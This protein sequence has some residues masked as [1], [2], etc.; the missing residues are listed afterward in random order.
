LLLQLNVNNNT[1]SL[2]GQYSHNP[3]LD[4]AFTGSMSV[5]PN[6]NALVGWGSK[7]FFSEYGPGGKLLLDAVWPGV[8]L[9]YRVLLTQNWVGK[10]FYPPSGAVR[11][12]HGHSTV[13]ASWDGA[14]QVAFWQILAGRRGHLKVITTVPKRGFE[15]AI[16][17]RRA[18]R[19]YKVRALGARHHALGTS[20][21]FPKRA[22]QGFNPGAY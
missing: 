9:S 7:P 1:A 15:T 10:P 2:V 19:A 17:L 8:D 21:V 16:H 13:Y 12:H 20:G 18:Y 14:T 5:L 22:G 3:P 11:K 4:S 6:G